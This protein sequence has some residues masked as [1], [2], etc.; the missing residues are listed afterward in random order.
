MR[1][2]SVIQLKTYSAKIKKVQLHFLP[3]GMAVHRQ[4]HFLLRDRTFVSPFLSNLF[5]M[6]DKRVNNK[7]TFSQAKLLCRNNTNQQKVWDV[8][9]SLN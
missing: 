8:G 1:K 9:E 6:Q 5:S 4:A 7:H 2:F 3:W